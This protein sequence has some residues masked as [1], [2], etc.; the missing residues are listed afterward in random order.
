MLSATILRE[1]RGKK[2]SG[3]IML[4]ARFRASS[5]EVRGM[6]LNLTR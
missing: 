4:S 2:D 3:R 5:A 1:T 6:F